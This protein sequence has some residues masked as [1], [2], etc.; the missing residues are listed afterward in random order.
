MVTGAKKIWLC[1]ICVVMAVIPSLRG[2][3]FWPVGEI[4]QQR[5]ELA[6]TLLRDY[7]RQAGLT[8]SAENAA[9]QVFKDFS[10]RC[11]SLPAQ[12]SAAL[13]T[14]DEL[15]TASKE[16]L[17][18]MSEA[19]IPIPSDQEL[20]KAAE[21]VYPL[22][23]QGDK[24]VVLYMPNPRYPAA[25]EGVYVG[26]QGAFIR[27]GN[28]RI[29][30]HD[31]LRVENNE[32]EVNKFDPETTGRLRREWILRRR[33]ELHEHRQRYEEE[34]AAAVQEQ[35]RR[36]LALR[37]E[38]A[39]YTIYQDEWLAPMALLQRVA[40][41]ICSDALREQALARQRARQSLIQ[42]TE[43]QAVSEYM[44]AVFSP[45]H[46]R[47]NPEATL[48]ALEQSKKERMEKERHQKAAEE[49]RK[50]AELEDA[51]QKVAEE[52]RLA[53]EASAPQQ[54]AT[55]TARP[56]SPP[57]EVAELRLLSPLF[58]LGGGF[59]I[60]LLALG[61]WIFYSRKQRREKS[62]TFR[63]FFEGKGKLQK[64]FWEQAD[65][66]PENFKYVA[67]LFP[68][69]ADANRALQHLSYIQVSGSGD[70][71]CGRD[72]LFGVYPHLDGAVAFVG[73]T[74]FTYALWREAS[75]VMPEE[76][77]AVYFKV[78]TEPH[79]SLDIPDVETLATESNLHIE[80]LG[81]EE[82]AGERGYVRCYKYRAESKDAALSFL[83]GIDV[84][85]EGISIQVETPE[86]IFGKD[87]NG[88]YTV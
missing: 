73:G 61:G 83:T 65:A 80:N 1:L 34:N 8:Q 56:E 63:K 52:A 19:A 84:N 17:Q 48:V 88:V 9:A 74:K 51:R 87:E 57:V 77:G 21:K 54:A 78:S 32:A 69:I 50:Q 38:H 85:E 64:D 35:Q 66:D 47:P 7:Y 72:I 59:L 53:A 16:A 29:R 45:G 37:N 5:L 43:D 20:A 12:I 71:K 62:D 39:G 13:L 40:G 41:Q 31:M 46:E 68:S 44:K 70:L 14:E 79:V 33:L 11:D 4:S 82:I 55:A 58:V 22:Y 86:G 28:A 25:V 67:Y 15:E 36:L 75:A 76:P 26:R 27:V 24:V 81:V 23:Q 18:R 2:E 10:S 60:V 49:A 42:T 3:S 30:V 6:Q